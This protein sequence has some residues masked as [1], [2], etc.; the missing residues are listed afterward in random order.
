[1]KKFKAFMKRFFERF[2]SILTERIIEHLEK[3]GKVKAV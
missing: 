3:E 1:M 2:V